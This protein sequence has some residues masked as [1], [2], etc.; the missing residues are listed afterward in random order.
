MSPKPSPWWPPSRFGRS[1]AATRGRCHCRNRGGFFSICAHRH[2]FGDG[3]FRRHEPDQRRPVSG[4]PHHVAGPAG[5]PLQDVHRILDRRSTTGRIVGRPHRHHR[6]RAILDRHSCRNDRR[7]PGQPGQL[8][9]RPCRHDHIHRDRRWAAQLHLPPRLRILPRPG[10]GNRRL[11]VR[12]PAAA[13]SRL[14][15]ELARRP[16]G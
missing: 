9:I 16:A 2:R 3:Q 5:A 12:Q 14:R 13:H 1:A 8:T 7:R 6:Q 15:H 11:R 4:F 10:A